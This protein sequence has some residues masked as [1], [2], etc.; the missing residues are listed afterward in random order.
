[1][2]W[3]AFP[4]PAA[5]LPPCVTY[6]EQQMA[7]AGACGFSVRYGVRGWATGAT[8]IAARPKSRVRCMSARRP[9]SSRH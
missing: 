5:E 2:S 8:Q 7:A 6:L 4:V 1:M 9:T 3:H